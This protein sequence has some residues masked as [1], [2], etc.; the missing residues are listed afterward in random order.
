[1][2]DLGGRLHAKTEMIQAKEKEG[3]SYHSLFQILALKVQ[4]FEMD[5]WCMRKV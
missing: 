2:L 1:M 5:T 4:E 3:G